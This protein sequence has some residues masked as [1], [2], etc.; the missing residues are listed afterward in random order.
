MSEKNFEDWVEFYYKKIKPYF[1]IL[2]R[3][4]KKQNLTIEQMNVIVN[5]V[6]C[7]AIDDFR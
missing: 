1:P 7:R 4:F 3:E 2:L 6:L 5:G